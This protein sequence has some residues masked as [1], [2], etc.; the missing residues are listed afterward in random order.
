MKQ[1]KKDIEYIEEK[2]KILKEN[3]DIIVL[4][5]MREERI[6]ELLEILKDY[7]DI[8]KFVIENKL[9]LRYISNIKL[10][11]KK[12]STEASEAYRNKDYDKCINGYKLLHISFTL[13]LDVF[14]IFNTSSILFI[15]NSL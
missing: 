11:Y 6:N 1:N 9:V 7:H 4:K 12:T 13:K 5:P 2:Y 10:D 15:L 8:D 14:I 3:K